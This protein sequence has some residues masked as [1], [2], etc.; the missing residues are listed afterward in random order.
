ME[1]AERLCDR[2]AV[3]D[4]GRIV[5]LDTPEKLVR[6]HGRGEPGAFSSSVSPLDLAGLRGLAGV[7][8]AEQAGDRVVVYGR[9]RPPGGRGGQ[10]SQRE[11]RPLPRPPHRTAD[12]GRCLPGPDR[13]GDEGLTRRTMQRILEADL[14]RIQ[15]LPA[16]THGLVFHPDLSPDDA[17]SVRQHLR[18]QAQSV[19]RRPGLRR[20]R[21]P[22]LHGDDHRH[23]R[24]DS[25]GHLRGFAPGTGRFAPVKATTLRPLAILG[26]QVFSSSR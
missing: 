13:P 15:A 25:P 6:G 9:E 2:V 5:A 11:P 3:I 10:L 19:L 14:G 23:E 1:E 4:R 16:R 24:P 17:V 22:G 8:A 26:S 21:R 20:H 7:T 18:Q 12:A